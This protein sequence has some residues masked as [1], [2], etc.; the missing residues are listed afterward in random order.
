MN[1]YTESKK[2][3]F[4]S[5]SNFID[6][7]FAILLLIVFWTF[8][9]G[10]PLIP[11]SFHEMTAAFGKSGP[12]ATE[13]FYEYYIYIPVLYF[14][15]QASYI[16]YFIK[17]II[18]GRDKKLFKRITIINILACVLIFIVTMV[19]VYLP[20]ASEPTLAF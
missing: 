15:V 14:L 9:F 7:F 19:C 5:K 18:S 16:G 4:L 1:G 11:A 6:L 13:I 17:V 20:L 8:Y 10:I 12:K 2:E 3:S